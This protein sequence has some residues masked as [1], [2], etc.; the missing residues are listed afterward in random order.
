MSALPPFLPPPLPPSLPPSLPPLPLP[1]RQMAEEVMKSGPSPG[2]GS[3]DNTPGFEGME[4][5]ARAIEMG[6]YTYVHMGWPNQSRYR[7]AG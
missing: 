4:A 7:W 6:T 1:S 5:L 2:E 3:V